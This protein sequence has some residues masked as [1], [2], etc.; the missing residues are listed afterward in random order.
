MSKASSSTM[1]G[2]QAE[3]DGW[4]TDR[5]ASM[6][7]QRNLAMGVAMVALIAAGG[8]GFG[9]AALAPLKSAEPYLLVHNTATGE[10]KELTK[11]RANPSE[12]QS[13]TEDD[14]VVSSF[15]VPYVIARETYDKDDYR[16]RAQQV[17]VFSDKRTYSLY[18][19]LFR[20]DDPK[21]NPFRKYGEDKV[22]VNVTRV[23]F[24]NKTTAQVGFT[25]RW[26]RAIGETSGSYVATI[27]FTFSNS[28]T[29]LG[30]RWKNPL[31]FQVT[32]YRVDQEVMNNG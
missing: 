26:I 11:L 9:L 19:A 5:Y 13:L 15:L 24:I 4:E 1:K 30:V 3:A 12:V 28:P 2:Y 29:E 17:Q 32:N 31:G 10:V 6:R 14:A 21:L 23:A 18:D 25:T 7:T 20:S 8:A 16:E 27:S 22:H